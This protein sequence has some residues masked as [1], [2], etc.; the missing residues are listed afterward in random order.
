M[1]TIAD[2]ITHHED[3]ICSTCSDICSMHCVIY[4]KARERKEQ[5]EKEHEGKG[6][7]DNGYEH[8]SSKG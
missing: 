4:R 8:Q 7:N 2:F 6:V 3:A 5:W 1:K